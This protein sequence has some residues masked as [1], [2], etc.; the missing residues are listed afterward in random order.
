MPYL[1]TFAIE[2]HHSITRARDI[3]CRHAL[4]HPIKKEVKVRF[5]I[6]QYSYHMTNL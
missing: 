6:H 1:V 3:P 5:P 2:I 4:I